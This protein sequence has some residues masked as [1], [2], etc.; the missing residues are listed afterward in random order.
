MEEDK[1]RNRLAG[2]VRFP[3]DMSS[4]KMV[5]ALQVK[6]DKAPG[7]L[8][9][10][11]V[12]H[13]PS[14]V[15]F[16]KADDIPGKNDLPYPDATIPLLAHKE[17]LYTGQPIGILTGPDLDELFKIRKKIS[18][19]ISAIP[20]FPPRE[21]RDRNNSPATKTIQKGN[22]SKGFAK[23]ERIIEG[24]YTL[25]I[26]E[27]PVYPRPDV[28]CSK[29]GGTYVLHLHSQWPSLLRKLTA[30]AAGISRK[31]V[32]MHFNTSGRT[33]DAHIW[34]SIPP[35]A[36]AVCITSILRQP[37]KLL[38]EEEKVYHKE[39]QYRYKA[40]MDA[41]GK[42][43]ALEAHIT[44]DTGA[45]GCFATEVASRICLGAAGL[46][47][48]RHMDIQV[49]AYQSNNPPWLP[50]PSWG[51]AQGAFGMELLAN[52]MA[53][54]SEQDPAHWRRQN[55]TMKGNIN[56][57]MGAIKKTPPLV[58]M[59]KSL[60]KASDYTRKHAAYRQIRTNRNHLDITPSAY[61]GIGLT[62]NRQGYEFLSRE[63]LLTAA[64][65]TATLGKD[66][67]F[68]VFLGTVPA[69][70]GMFALWK[71]LISSQLSIDEKQIF[72]ITDRPDE[73]SFNGPSCLSRNAIVFTKLIDQCCSIIQKKRF[74]EGL[75]IT[76]TRSYR[77][78]TGAEWDET[79]MMGTPFSSPS[80]AAAVVEVALYTATREISI[81][82]I[83][84]SLHCGTILDPS[85]A[86]SFIE[87][88]VRFALTQCM[89][90]QAIKPTIFPEL[91]IFFDED[92]SKNPAP[93]GLEG[94]ALGTI[95]AA[96]AQALSQA[97]GQSITGLPV[98]SA[99][100]LKGGV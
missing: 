25:A 67:N 34:Q 11:S 56:T 88:E 66:G 10:I 55:L 87:A 24:E 99:S 8:M 52:N 77:R 98:N 45:Y 93:G 20:P 63:R 69:A 37:V 78:R 96:F 61:A 82:R 12:P 79:N 27:T 13:L 75:P 23:A 91:H 59:I 74:R 28:F 1:F 15:H 48:C 97:T 38:N 17:V 64:S 41:H 49:R 26:P 18:T 68:E 2:L 16:F 95:P 30:M 46:Y 6:A 76:E 85:S 31:Q 21:I 53:V 33:W 92:E 94:L 43:T 36:M 62:V 83:W 100:L 14:Q 54:E 60:S 3:E 81:P 4:K 42:L 89:D 65:V 40:G 35:A 90:K 39:I 51:L 71:K 19:E 72:L 5:H 9:G 73:H 22:P 47:L 80:W 70:P 58:S 44:L 7:I 32:E 57:T 86:R 29:E 84:L 50:L